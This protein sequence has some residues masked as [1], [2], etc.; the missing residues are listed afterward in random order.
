[1]LTSPRNP[2]VVAVARLHEPRHR[3]GSGLTL[4]E[5]PH[6]VAEAVAAGAEIQQLFLVEDDDWTPPIPIN[7]TRVSR[8]VLRRIAGTEHPRGPVAVVIEPAGN[9]LT[10]VDTV[11]LW[12]IADPGNVGAIIRSAV[13]F[14]WAVAVTAGTADPWSPKVVRA[15]AATSLFRAP[16]VTLGSDPL[17]E[18]V[19]AGLDPVATVADG[20]LPRSRRTTR[21]HAPC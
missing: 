11:V 20:G 13:A 16:P 3:K 6:Q 7:V 21:G 15:A 9:P 2:Q 4:V 10:A 14:G 5:G 18:L 1:M 12:D 17:G 19:A 8:D